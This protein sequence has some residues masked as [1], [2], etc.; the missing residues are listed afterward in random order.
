VNL[1]FFPQH[2]LGLAGMPRRYADYPDCFYV[3][4]KVSSLGSFITVIR[5][6]L[7]VV[8]L[9]ESFVTQRSVMFVF[10]SPVHLEWSSRLPTS[11]HTHNES[12]KVFY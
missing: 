4:N 5:V 8:I 11:F 3:W 2:F 10:N 12:V 7:F 9:W 1:T 6:L